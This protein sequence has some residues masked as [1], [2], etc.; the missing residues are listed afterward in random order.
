LV[1]DAVAVGAAH[2][3][4]GEHQVGHGATEDDAGDEAAAL[5]GH[6]VPSVRAQRR[7]LE[8][9]GW[10]WFRSDQRNGFGRVEHGRAIAVSADDGR[11]R[12]DARNGE[13]GRQSG[14]RE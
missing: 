7:A 13:R 2:V 8:L 4:A 12:I 3:G 11:T 6:V 5:D 1:A 9:L 10:N 14:R